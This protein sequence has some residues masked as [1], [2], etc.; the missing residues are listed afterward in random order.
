MKKRIVTGNTEVELYDTD[1]IERMRRRDTDG[2]GTADYIDSDYTKPSD[3]YRF[4]GISSE[5]YDKLRRSGFD[6]K[7]NCHPD[8]TDPHRHILRY[9]ESQTEEIDRIL[10]PVFHRAVVK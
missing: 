6:V 1:P 8:K 10:K 4:R 2:D 7:N 3:D 9:T 5:E